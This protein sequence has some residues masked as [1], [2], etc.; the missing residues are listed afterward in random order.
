MRLHPDSSSIPDAEAHA[1]AAKGSHWLK[2]Y[3]Q[4]L[5]QTAHSW[6][7]HEGPR[8]A[9]SLSLYS[10]LSLAPLVMLSI[11]LASLAFGRIAAQE[12]MIKEVRGLMGAAGANTIQ[13]VL[14]YGKA[15]HSGSLASV[16]GILIL[17]F[18]ASSVF[19]ELQSALNKI[20]DAQSAAGSGV[21]AFIKSRL[22]SFALVLGFGFLL[23][24]SLVF[25][26]ALAAFTGFF[27]AHLAVPHS[28][29]TALD[30][31]VSCGGI[32]VLIALILRY[33]PDVSLRWRDVWQGALATALLFTLGKALLGLY[34]GKAAVGSAYGAAGSL[35]V[36]IIWVYYTAMIFY[37]G[38][39]FTRVRARRG[40]APRANVLPFSDGG[41]G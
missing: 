1:S 29:L 34:L 17:L 26:A 6:S 39:E 20:W 4:D 33:I 7:N 35:I 19:G 21:T 12:A 28:L 37:F 14:E 2:R 22:V 31:V 24:V 23:L 36:V 25:S 8:L 15:P 13:M 10:L 40:T 27:S 30:A 16:I 11:A 9:A 5:Q 32:F 38:A 3:W 18:G 41:R